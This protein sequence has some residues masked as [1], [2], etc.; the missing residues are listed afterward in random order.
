MQSKAIGGVAQVV[1]ACGSYPQCPGFKSLHRHSLIRARS[2][3]SLGVAQK[4]AFF[5]GIVLLYTF[6]IES[7]KKGGSNAKK[8]LFFYFRIGYR[9]AP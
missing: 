1:R 2:S 9:G 7:V 4:I 5:F 3:A 6:Y 8:E